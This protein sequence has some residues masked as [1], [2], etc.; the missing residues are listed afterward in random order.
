[1]LEA[2]EFEDCYSG[3]REWVVVEASEEDE[4]IA[5]WVDC[6][7]AVS[8]VD[9]VVYGPHINVPVIAQTIWMK[10]ERRDGG[11]FEHLNR[12]NITGDTRC[13]VYEELAI[14]G[15]IEAR[16]KGYDPLER[17]KYLIL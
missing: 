15:E 2:I 11:A 4:T 7:W 12:L 16:A 10:L 17:Y 1:M 14:M 13:A 3:H 6:G 8:D 9:G 5:S